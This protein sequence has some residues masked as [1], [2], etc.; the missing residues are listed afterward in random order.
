MRVMERCISAWPMPDMQA[1]IHSLRQ[2]FSAD[3]NKPFELKP[4]FPFGSPVSRLA[5]SPPADPLSEDRNLTPHQAPDQQQHFQH[6]QFHA[7]PMTPP[8]SNVPEESK[9]GGPLSARALAMM[10]GR[11]GS[12]HGSQMGGD[13]GMAW[14]PTRLFEYGLTFL[15]P[16]KRVAQEEIANQPSQWNTAFGTPTSATV[17][18]SATSVPTQQQ[19]QSPTT[20][21]STASTVSHD[22]GGVHDVLQTSQ[23][24]LTS[25]VPPVSPMHAPSPYSAAAATPTANP[26]VSPSMWQDTVASTYVPQDLK[27]RWDGVGGHSWIHGGDQQQVRSRAE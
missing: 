4:S 17:S 25:T 10:Q 5:P 8:L 22:L 9:D 27:R 14:N 16:E 2:A 19:Q 20:F 3:I 18:A 11:Q 26:F 21:S 13:D 7:A 12:P 24:A 15:P 23:Y 1:Q 6:H